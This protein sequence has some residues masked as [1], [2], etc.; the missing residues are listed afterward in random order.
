MEIRTTRNSR[1]TGSQ[2]RPSPPE[3]GQY[4]RRKATQRLRKSQTTTRRLAA[5]LA[6]A[7]RMAF[8]VFLLAFGVALFHYAYNSD[9][10][11]LRTVTFEGT[12]NAP[13]GKLE[14][15]VR[16]IFP[17]N[18]LHIRLQDIRRH[19]ESDPWVKRAEIRRI[20]PSGLKIQVEERVPSTLVELGGSLMICDD[21][22]ILLALYGPAYGK[23]DVPVFKGLMGEDPAGYRL[24]Q[25]E[26]SHRVRLARTML[27]ELEGGSPALS[28]RVSEVDLSDRSNLR[29]LLVDDTTEIFLGDRD[30]LKRMRSLLA[31]MDSYLQ[32]RERY[33]EI[34][35]VDLRFD[36]QII[37][38]P[39]GDSAGIQSRA[40]A[41]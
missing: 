31:N 33:G 8:L 19:V 23:L 1:E 30:F 41:P 28:R 7:G 18:L 32:L 36:G 3:R 2:E 26:N 21:E 25:Q 9:M 39:P 10:F 27:A 29:I 15:E 22:G 12:V 16:R 38:R 4:L 6:L 40:E 11:I 20:L 24:H 34:V 14:E 5:W 35:S 37:Y 17:R 13:V